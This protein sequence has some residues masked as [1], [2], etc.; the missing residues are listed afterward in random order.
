MSLTTIS[1]IAESKESAL[2]DVEKTFRG[3]QFI[4]RRDMP[5]LE[6]QSKPLGASQ[7]VVFIEHQSSDASERSSQSGST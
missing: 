6:L 1:L 2:A 3:T 7:Y 4:V 5:V